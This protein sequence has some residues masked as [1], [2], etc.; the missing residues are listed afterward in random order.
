[1]QWIALAALLATP[2][3]C[4]DDTSS[5]TGGSGGGG[6]TQSSATGG[7]VSMSTSS[8]ST[9]T[10]GSCEDYANSMSACD[11]CVAASCC[12]ELSACLESEDCE[13]VT[14][15]IFDDCEVGDTECNEACQTAHPTGYALLEA[16]ADCW[17]ANCQLECTSPGS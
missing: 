9:S 15:C 14:K 6:A 1:M 3:G 4:G 16:Y 7:S 10:G 11:Q 17:D 5:G 12:E 8:A 13:A 2:V